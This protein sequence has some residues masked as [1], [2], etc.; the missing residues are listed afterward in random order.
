MKNQSSPAPI[1]PSPDREEDSQARS[2]ALRPLL[3]S[4]F[5]PTEDREQLFGEAADDNGVFD[6]DEP[7]PQKGWRRFVHP[8]LLVVLLPTLVVAGFEYLVA[9]DQYE[10]SAQFI[11]RT[12]QQNNSVN[13]LGQMLG[14]GAGSTPADVHSVDAYLLSHDAV[15]ALGRDRLV[16]MFRHTDS[17][18]VTRLWFADPEPETLL[19][20]YRGKVN[21]TTSSETG[22]TL[23]SVR[24]FQRNDAK[25]LADDLLK[26]GEQRVNLLN[27]RMFEA[28][29]TAAS[30]QVREAEGAIDE[31]DRQ[32]TEFRQA[33]RDADPERTSSA[34]IQLA[35]SLQERAAQARAQ[36]DA[37]AAVLPSSA[38]QY[39]ATVRRVTAL[40]RQVAAVKGRLAGSEGSVAA[41]LGEYEQLQVRQQLAAKR[42]EAAQASFQSA[43]EQLVKQQL[44]I[45]PVVKPNLPGKSLYPERLTIIA[46]VFFGL[47]FAYAIGWLILS[48][49][50]EHA[51]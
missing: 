9:A 32:M 21:V 37:M 26:L 22:I 4:S 30:R 45:I 25:A 11:V 5:P 48:G 39:S 35:T 36:L 1:A 28:G 6:Y 12:P 13:S 3:L 10:S 23:L 51:E 34:E 24:G 14:I 31:A 43:R 41:G 20:Y 17:D 7:P 2:E 18:P 19:K 15:S 47:L 27:Q 33:R 44:F 38:P 50:R 29:L 8:F 16:A 49:F 40:E 42:F 46:I